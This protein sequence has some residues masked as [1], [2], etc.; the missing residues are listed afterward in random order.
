MSL[1]L[2]KRREELKLALH[3][4]KKQT[5][6]DTI[7]NWV[8]RPFQK[9]IANNEILSTILGTLMIYLITTLVGAILLVVFRESNILQQVV[10]K[11]NWWIIPL[12]ITST[13]S[14]IVENAFLHRIII[15]FRD[16]VLETVNAVETLD[17]IESWINFA[18]NKKLALLVGV[19]GG[20]ISGGWLVL[21][22]N[23]NL[24]F[25]LGVGFTVMIVLFAMQ[26]SLFIGFLLAILSLTMQMRRYHLILFS[27]DPS[28]SQ[29]ISTLS[30]FLTN[31]VYVFAL[32]GAFITYGIIAT[33]LLTSLYYAL[34]IFWCL[35]VLIFALNQYSLAQIIQR[36]KWKTLNA[37]QQQIQKI[38]REQAIP[39]KDARETVIWLLDYHDRV[40]VTRNSALNL[41]AGFNLLN[42]LLLPVLAFV[43]GNLDKII[44]LFQ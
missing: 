28:N 16:E 15:I 24:G 13:I 3:N 20:I 27:S 32:Y 19:I 1:D 9:M 42:S 29:I 8:N 44:A 43:L 33:G 37:I 12:L 2:L 18:Y 4:G 35:I 34:P 14:M 38:Q 31:F 26:S 10:L 6:V 17:N 41:E 36:E 21:S 11:V 40:K 22:L 25:S 5:L 30:G 7:L 39:D 23:S